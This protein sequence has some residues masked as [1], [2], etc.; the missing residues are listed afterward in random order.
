MGYANRGTAYKLVQQALSSWTAD[1]VAEL[2]RVENDRPDA[3]QLPIWPAAMA[4]DVSGCPGGT[5]D[6]SGA[7]SIEGLHDLEPDQ[8]HAQCE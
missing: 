2:R 6:H 7:M 1:G 3:L 4:G 5:E 8:N